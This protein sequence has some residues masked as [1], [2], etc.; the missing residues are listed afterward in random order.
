MNACTYNPLLSSQKPCKFGLSLLFGLPA[1]S[2]TCTGWVTVIV[3][4]Q[5]GRPGDLASIGGR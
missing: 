4:G 2:I 3:P 5:G 1:M